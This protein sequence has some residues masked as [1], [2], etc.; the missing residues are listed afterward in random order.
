VGSVDE[1]AVSPRTRRLVHLFL[2]AFAVTGLAHLELFPF[3]GFRLFSELR[4]EERVSW[5]LRTV[6]DDGT[7][8]PIPLGSLPVGFRNSTK[9]LLE[10]P[11]LSDDERDAVCDGW[12][13]PARDAGR[14][15]AEVRVYEVTSSVRPGAPPPQRRLA[16]T[17]GTVP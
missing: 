11:D 8:T 16:Y 3:S 14:S 12:A 13:E 4:G 6:A 15:V 5:Q 2:L 1:E 17:C 10:F 9:L 7:E